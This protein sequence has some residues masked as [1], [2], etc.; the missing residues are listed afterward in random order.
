MQ[1]VRV[2]VCEREVVG[3]L[4][5]SVCLCLCIYGRMNAK[6]VHEC[7]WSCMFGCTFVD[8]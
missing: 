4:M 2:C 1:G 7:G 8:V 6:H 3:D 5:I